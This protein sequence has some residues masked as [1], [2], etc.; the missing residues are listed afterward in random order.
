[1][2]VE[3]SVKNFLSICEQATLSLVAVKGQELEETNTFQP[4]APSTPA[5]LRS[6]AIYGPNAAGKSN[7]IRALQTMERLVI[8]SAGQSQ[9]GE[10][11]AVTPFLLN[12]SARSQ[13]SE[14]EVTFI[15]QGVRYQYGFA[16]TKERI[17]E[18]W[19]LAY[20]K[21][22]PQRWIDRAYDEKSQSYAWRTMD[23]LTGKKQTWQAATRPN[24]LFLS[25]AVQL[26]NQQLKPVFDWFSDTLHV[27]GFGRWN[28]TF[29]IDLCE[30]EK[31]REKIMSFL[32]AA[33]IDIEGIELQNEKFNIND[34][35]DDMSEAAKNEIVEKYQG[36]SFVSVK[37][38]HV[39]DSGKKVLFDM[40]D[41]SD[42]TQKIFALAGPW[43][44]ILENGY[45]LIIDEL[46]DNLHPL[47][48]EFLIKLF[49]SENTNPKNAQLIF[50]THDTSILNQEIFR[51]DQIWFCDKDKD[52]ATQLY[53]LTDFSPRKG[54]ENLER[55]YLSGRY[56]ALPYLKNINKVMGY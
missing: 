39:S 27:T 24:A 21:G 38:S 35:P 41:E 18:E 44:D 9:A 29:S 26:N 42:G 36:K 53:P 48:V 8:E 43:L 11:L 47:I 15:S 37:T 14:F 31:T 16:A 55:G 25:T 4:D 34:L 49:H 54:V 20:P 19:L 17:T 51:R 23:K 32:Q 46:H 56:G 2:L 12:E 6:A 45:V 7:V 52:H 10:A 13:P 1:M 33:D 22:R 50:S 3:F 5:M 28:P 40:D 30:K